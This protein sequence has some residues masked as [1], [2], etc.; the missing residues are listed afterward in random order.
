[1]YGKKMFKMEQLLVASNCTFLTI[2]PKLSYT[3]VPKTYL[4]CGP[5]ASE[6]ECVDKDKTAQKCAA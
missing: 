4:C 2:F 1:M 3:G 5:L 6:H